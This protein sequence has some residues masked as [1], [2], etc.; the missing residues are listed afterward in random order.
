MS[1][2]YAQRAYILPLT[3]PP[4]IGASRSSDQPA[5]RVCIGLE[6]LVP[7]IHVGSYT[8]FRQPAFVYDAKFT[9]HPVPV[10]YLHLSI[11]SW[12]QTWPG[13]A[14]SAELCRKEIRFAGGPADDTWNSG[15]QPVS[16]QH[17]TL[18]ETQQPNS[19]CPRQQVINGGIGICCEAF[20]QYGRQMTDVLFGVQTIRFSRLQN[21]E[22]DRACPCPVGRVG[23][24]PSL[25]VDDNRGPSG[26]SY[27][28]AG[29]ACFYA[30]AFF[31]ARR[32][33]NSRW[34][35]AL[36]AFWHSSRS[37]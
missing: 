36:R 35:F 23:E 21:G 19:F 6:E 9:V 32:F 26:A 17:S 14:L 20:R 30:L 7:V 2:A 22:Y 25:S 31:S 3:W 24:Q 12:L 16:A 18:P 11:S 1:R 34:F 33:R 15:F 5:R 8:L 13:T 28:K 10:L 29:S 37:Q 4:V 27:I